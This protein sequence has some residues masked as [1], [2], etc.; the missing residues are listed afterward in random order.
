MS[1]VTDSRK[2]YVFVCVGCDCLDQGRKDQTTCSAACRV[3]VHRHPERMQELRTYAE[4]T[5]ITVAGIQQATA[6]DRLRPDLA[7]QIMARTLTTAG[8]QA[9]MDRSFWELVQQARTVGAA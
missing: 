6:I 2:R 9:E 7:D 8:A 3:R 4:Q 1:R 5:N